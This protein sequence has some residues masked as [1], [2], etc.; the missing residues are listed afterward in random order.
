MS[1]RGV[2]ARQNSNGG[3]T[4]VYHHW[5]SYPTGLGVTL[6]KL[7][8]H[9][10][11]DIDKMVH[12]LI[13]DHPAGFSTIV[14]KDFTLPVGY[15][16]FDKRICVV[17]G[18]PNWEHYFQNWEHHGKE[19]T[20]EAKESME[21]EHYQAF[22]HSFD[23]IPTRNPECF[24][25]GD[26]HEEALQV[27]EENASAMGC[28]YAYVFDGNGQMRILSSYNED[29]S[30]MVGMFGCGNPQA[31]WRPIAIIDLNGFEPNWEEIK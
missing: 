17:C 2:I 4:G 30:K 9:H 16:E 3:F 14:G 13:D 1:T 26:R 6:W 25:H 12:T 10:F 18:K 20:P 28:E 8:H 19:L 22:D 24:C 5:D 23:P 15:N 21:R 11:R 29:N 27:T 31:D 7:Y